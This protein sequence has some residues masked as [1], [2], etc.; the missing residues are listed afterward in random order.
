MRGLI[1]GAYHRPVSELNMSEAI[2]YVFWT[3]K[4]LGWTWSQLDGIAPKRRQ[5]KGCRVSRHPGRSRDVPSHKKRA[6]SA[7]NLHVKRYME[8]HRGESDARQLFKDAVAAWK[9]GGTRRSAGKKAAQTKRNKKEEAARRAAV[10]Q[11]LFEERKAEK[12]AREKAGRDRIIAQHGRMRIP[13]KAKA[14][15]PTQ[16]GKGAAY[17]SGSDDE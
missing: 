6:P 9:A 17:D 4:D 15:A 11:D 8:E 7:Y 5:P 16:Y 13:R 14:A 3:A 12:A 10:K 1:K 2:E